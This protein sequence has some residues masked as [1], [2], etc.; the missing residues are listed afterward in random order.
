[1]SLWNGFLAGGVVIPL[2]VFMFQVAMV[3][4]GLL[5]WQAD[6][7][8][9][10]YEGHYFILAFLALSKAS[11][12]LT[13]PPLWQRG[14]SALIRSRTAGLRSLDSCGDVWH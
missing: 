9:I 2:L 3:L 13:T 5:A 12:V 10:V 8:F 14:D 4:K 1:M 6:Y 7:F 11:Q